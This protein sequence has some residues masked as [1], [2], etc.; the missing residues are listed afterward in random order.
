[1][2]L[3]AT[4]DFTI[5]HS[6]FIGSRTFFTVWL[7]GKD[8]LS[9]DTLKIIVT[10]FLYCLITLLEYRDLLLN[11]LPLQFPLLAHSLRPRAIHTIVYLLL[12]AVIQQKKV[13][14]KLCDV[15]NMATAI[16]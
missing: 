14:D 8:K 13:Y 10:A 12:C 15:F 9:T 1:M 7:F 11:T 4:V 6:G 2:Q 3:A 16:L 5:F